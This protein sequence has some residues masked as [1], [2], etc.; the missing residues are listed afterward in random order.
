M[1]WSYYG[2]SRVLQSAVRCAH[3]EYGRK[4]QNRTGND[5]KQKDDRFSHLAHGGISSAYTEA[6]LRN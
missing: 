3:E 5:G 2:L 4:E 6:G 1:I